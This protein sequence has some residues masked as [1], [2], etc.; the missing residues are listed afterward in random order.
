MWQDWLIELALGTGKLF[1]NPL[2][3]WFFIIISLATISRIKKERRSFGTKVFDVF[4]ETSFTWPIAIVSGLLLSVVAVGLGFI[5]SYTAILLLSIFTIL[6]T[7]G[8][9]FS[10]L[11]SAYTFGF[12]YLALLLL[13]SLIDGQVSDFWLEDLK[14]VHVVSFTVLLGLFIVIEA[15]I[16]LRMDRN[17]TFPEL[18]KGNRG[19]WIGQ[20]RIKKM[21][22]IPFFTL[23]P[24]GLIIPFAD[25]WPVF[26][27]NGES[28]GLI[29]L[30]VL[31]GFEHV[32][33]G[34][35][36][37]KSTRELGQSLLILGLLT[38][39][40]SIAGYYLSVFTLISVAVAIIGRELISY[41]FRSKD[42]Q[43]QPFFG[44]D[45]KGL[46]VLGVIPGSP[47]DGLDLTVGERIMKVN[48]KPVSDEQEFYE[49]LQLNSAYCKLDI[50]DERGEIR[51]A[52]RALYQGEH[53]ELGMLFTKEHYRKIEQKQLAVEEG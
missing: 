14:Q 9:K 32:V 37:I 34:T 39:G 30:P 7:I 2:F 36:P 44:P 40:I 23:I 48:G 10:W 11:S 18:V 15:A 53:H 17:D 50:R 42:Q 47:A 19:K 20:H 45:T 26:Q 13:P 38:V 6:F 1:L 21:A 51:F 4:S 16:M 52:Q 33:K 43:K 5:I 28:Y 29:L 3:Y 35:M 8:R 41:R 27:I 24:N 49:A 46:L 22:M 31:I 25:W 12:T